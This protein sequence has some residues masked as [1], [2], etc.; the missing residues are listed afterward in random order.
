MY[1]GVFKARLL[2]WFH[3]AYYYDECLQNKC[4]GKGFLRQF[5]VGCLFHFT[6]LLTDV[7]FFCRS[8]KLFFFA[9]N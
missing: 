9:Y 1:D 2:V 8:S 7:F 4:I 5:L 3:V 6:L